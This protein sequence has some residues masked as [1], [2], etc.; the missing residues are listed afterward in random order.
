MNSLK[1]I[2]SRITTLEAADTV[3]ANVGVNIRDSGGSMREVS[4]ILDDLSGRWSS[5]SDEQRQNIGVT[6]AGRYQLSRLTNESS[7]LEIVG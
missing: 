2:Y 7:L 5:L 4:D 3:L 6:I 1:T